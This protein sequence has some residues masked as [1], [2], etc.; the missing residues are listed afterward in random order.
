MTGAQTTAVQRSARRSW[1][2]PARLRRSAIS[3]ATKLTFVA[4]VLAAWQLLGGRG[5]LSGVPTASDCLSTLAD[6]VRDGDVWSPLGETLKAWAIGLALSAAIAI[7]IG[8]LLGAS[9]LAYRMTRLLID[10]CRTIPTLA[11]LPL[12]V[13]LYGSGLGSTLLLVVFACVWPILLQTIYGVRDIDAVVRE[14][15]RSYRISR[16]QWRRRVVLPSAG[17]YIATGLRIAA[18]ISLLLVLSSEI[19]IPVPGIGQA[20]V[21]AQ[22]GGAISEMYAWIVLA[23]LVGVAIN[24]VFVRLERIVLHWHP[25]QRKA[26]SA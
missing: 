21:V 15:C 24:A 12:A 23:G 17:P 2:L 20:I 19:L 5:T 18:A 22:L 11:L 14:T 10:F 7:P 13:L 25:S 6:L 1:A 8:F 26:A 4:L 3:W 9:S 16:W